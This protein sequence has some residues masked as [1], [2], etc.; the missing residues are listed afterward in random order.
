MTKFRLT[1]GEP[2]V[3]RDATD[4]VGALAALPG[5]KSVAPHANTPSLL[6]GCVVCGAAST[7]DQPALPGQVGITTNGLVLGRKLEG[8]A[9]AG[10]TSVNVSLD[11]LVRRPGFL[12]IVPSA[13]PAKHCLTPPPFSLSLSIL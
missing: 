5:V 11:T 1:G 10:L 6:R 13:P 9:R 12:A 8:L 4:I 2:L 7:T 3:R